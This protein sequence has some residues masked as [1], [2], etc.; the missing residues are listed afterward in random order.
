MSH[1]AHAPTADPLV[2]PGRTDLAPI[3]AEEIDAFVEEMGENTL[4]CEHVDHDAAH[5]PVSSPAEWRVYLRCPE[6]G[7]TDAGLICTPGYERYFEDGLFECDRCQGCAPGRDF[8]V[9]AVRV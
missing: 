9:R 7:R 3:T 2:A 1:L 4:P 5:R 6:C 8:I